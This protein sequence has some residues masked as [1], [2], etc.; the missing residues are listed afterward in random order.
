MKFGERINT[1]LFDT[2]RNMSSGDMKREKHRKILNEILAK[3][4]NSKILQKKHK[5][6]EQKSAGLAHKV[7]IENLSGFQY[8][9][10]FVW[11]L[12]SLFFNGL[13]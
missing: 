4:Q 10:R 11:T 12:L 5:G 6:D 1:M 9:Q 7:N 3:T 8:S 13:M 2:D